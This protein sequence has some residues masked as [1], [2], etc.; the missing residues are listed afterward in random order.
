MAN[1]NTEMDKFSH[2]KV[3]NEKTTKRTILK[4]MNRKKILVSNVLKTC[5]D[6]N[7]EEFNS[8]KDS[9]SILRKAQKRKYQR[10]QDK[11]NIEKRDFLNT[12]ITKNTRKKS[13]EDKVNTTKKTKKTLGKSKDIE[14]NNNKITQIYQKDSSNLSKKL[15]MVL[16]LLVIVAIDNCLKSK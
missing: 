7:I 8:I 15:L 13:E 5:K 9:I 4:H 12:N 1:I 14:G 11:K 6:H 3:C 10:E 16:T 2:C